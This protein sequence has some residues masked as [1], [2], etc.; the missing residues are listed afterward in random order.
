MT[1]NRARFVNIGQQQVTSFHH[2][3][4]TIWFT[5]FLFVL[6]GLLHSCRRLHALLI[7]PNADL[8]CLPTECGGSL[9]MKSAQKT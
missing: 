6:D 1:D 2:L 9:Q 8:C 5:Y 3:K 7:T 4:T